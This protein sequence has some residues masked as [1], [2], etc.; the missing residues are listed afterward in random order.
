[1]FAGSSRVL[2]RYL[3]AQ[4]MS[5]V[6]QQSSP[7]LPVP[8]GL[9]SPTH[10]GLGKVVVGSSLHVADQV[11]FLLIFKVCVVLLELPKVAPS[12]YKLAVLKWDVSPDMSPH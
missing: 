10:L 3:S 12:W 9:S 11:P 1:M 4:C 8:V 5:E 7:L 2:V 6:C